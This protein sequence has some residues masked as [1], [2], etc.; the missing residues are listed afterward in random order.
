[1]TEKG[2]PLSKSEEF[3]IGKLREL[4]A[5]SISAIEEA[6]KQLVTMITV[7][8]GIYAAVLAFSGIKEM[9]RG[10]VLALICYALPIFLWLAALF[11]ALM[12]SHP[13]AYHCQE[14][15]PEETFDTIAKFKY[16]RLRL[17]FILVVISFVIAAGGIMYWLY[18]ASQPIPPHVPPRV[19]N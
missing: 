1:M 15:S 16:Q 17:S 18:T 8:Q 7:M 4:R 3:W 11:F 12:V 2:I 10:N 5:G 6:A 19:I 9:P 14:D 13:R